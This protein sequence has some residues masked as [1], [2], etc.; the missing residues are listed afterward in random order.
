V[1][2]PDTAVEVGQSFTITGTVTDQSPG[3]KDTPA[4]SDDDMSAWMEYMHM[5]KNR[6]KDAKG[7]DVTLAAVDPNGNTIS[8]GQATSDSD[9]CFGLTWT[10]EVPGLYQI[11]ASFPG[12]DSYGSSRAS[13]YLSAIGAPQATAPPEATPAP[14]TDTYV[15]GTG[16]A[17]IVAI[18]VGVLLILRKK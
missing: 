18:A 7:V 5:Q 2:A 13:T 4:I 9:G 14:M 12:S 17:V 10:P 6:P 3:Q 8:I 11:L 15:V 1:S 16:I